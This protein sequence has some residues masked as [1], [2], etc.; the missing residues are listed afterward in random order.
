VGLVH[1]KSQQ[2]GKLEHAALFHDG[3]WNLAPG[4]FCIEGIMLFYQPHKD[5]WNAYFPFFFAF[6]PIQF[7]M[8]EYVLQLFIEI[9][10]VLRVYLPVRSQFSFPAPAAI[11]H[12][13]E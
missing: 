11:A 3:L 1:H 7:E 4:I 6:I 9:F 12:K 10:P 5:A 13:M 8:S 2:P